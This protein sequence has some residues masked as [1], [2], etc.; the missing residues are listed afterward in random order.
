MLIQK[1]LIV[2]VLTI[3]AASCQISLAKP[4]EN[5]K[6]TLMEVEG[7]MEVFPGGHGLGYV[8]LDDGKCYDLALPA[9]VLKRSKHWDARRVQIIGSLQFRPR[10][11]EMMWFDVKDRKIEG[12]GC[13]ED[14]IYVESIR[15]L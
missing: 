14:V 7:V 8:T 6:E 5:A 2:T 9:K 13:S 15:M 3:A 1:L 10:M 12:F 11:E 4:A